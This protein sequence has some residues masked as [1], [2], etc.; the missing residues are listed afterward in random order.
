[1]YDH[2]RMSVGQGALSSKDFT[3]MMMMSNIR[4]S[5]TKGHPVSIGALGS[6][7][8]VSGL[9]DDRRGVEAQEGC[10]APKPSES[11]DSAGLV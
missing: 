6:R 11:V 8:S 7:V 2:Y 4:R 1:M 3:K 5:D 10:A 9:H